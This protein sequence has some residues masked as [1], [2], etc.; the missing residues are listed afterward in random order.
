MPLRLNPRVEQR[1]KDALCGVFGP[2]LRASCL[3]SGRIWGDNPQVT[4]APSAPT[5]R[6]KDGFEK[7]STLRLHEKAPPHDSRVGRG[8]CT[9]L[10]F[11]NAPEDDERGGGA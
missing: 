1:A 9:D 7:K 6:R 8:R 4:A 5:P 10:A 11:P 3:Q 2:V